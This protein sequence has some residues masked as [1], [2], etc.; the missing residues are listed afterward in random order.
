MLNE[1]L[2]V[3]WVWVHN[4]KCLMPVYQAT[5]IAVLFLVSASTNY[6]V[7]NLQSALLFSRCSALLL[8][9]E[10]FMSFVQALNRPT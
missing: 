3:A 9:M 4:S 1:D 5:G 10:E 6:L 8:Q 7:P 2:T